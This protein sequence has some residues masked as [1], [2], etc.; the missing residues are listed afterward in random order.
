MRTYHT[1]A[2]TRLAQSLDL[3]DRLADAPAPPPTPEPDPRVLVDGERGPEP[4][5]VDPAR[6]RAFEPDVPTDDER[7]GAHGY[8]VRFRWVSEFLDAVQQVTPPVM[9]WVGRAQRCGPR[10]DPETGAKRSSGRHTFKRHAT[11]THLNDRDAK[12]VRAVTAARARGVDVTRSDTLPARSRAVV[13][14]LWMRWSV[15]TCTDGLRVYPPNWQGPTDPR[16]PIVP[17]NA[18]RLASYLVRLA[19]HLVSLLNNFIAFATGTRTGARTTRTPVEQQKKDGCAVHRGPTEDQRLQDRKRQML[20][21]F[22]EHC[23]QLGDPLPAR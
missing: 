1:A 23:K 17:K 15:G 20:A 21:D 2:P 14:D 16:E 7:T 18:L 22:A 5:D 12:V 3:A 9:P 13:A 11:E 4:L 19:D 10:R 8:R 6:A